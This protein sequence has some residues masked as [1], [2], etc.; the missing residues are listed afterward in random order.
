MLRLATNEDLSFVHSLFM[1]EAIN[2]FLAF[3]PSPLEDFRSAYLEML[4]ESEFLILE[5]KGEPTGMGQ[6][7]WGTDRFAH[8]AQLCGI[9]IAPAFQGQGL[10]RQLMEGLLERARGAG[11]RRIELTV[12]ADNPGAIS[13]YESFGFRREGTMKD[14]F[15]RAGRE[16]YFDEH[17]MALLL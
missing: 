5:R 17:M 13:F 6:I 11:L 12:S 9:A 8:S 16:G 4:A 2:P 14:F 1:H 7:R 10:G 3:D 15:T